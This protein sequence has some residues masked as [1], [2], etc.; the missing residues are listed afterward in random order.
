M[1]D[2][3]QQHVS[4]ADGLVFGQLHY[5]HVVMYYRWQLSY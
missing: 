5:T 2:A 1:T 3:Y 4:T